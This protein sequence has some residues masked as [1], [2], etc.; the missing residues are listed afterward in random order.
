MI[1]IIFIF[2]LYLCRDKILNLNG[3]KYQRK[4]SFPFH[5]FV[6]HH[7]LS[8]VVSVFFFLNSLL[9]LSKVECFAYS[10]SLNC[11]LELDTFVTFTIHDL[12][13]IMSFMEITF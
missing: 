11:L 12:M 3:G 1:I 8:V 6:L 5:S 7:M 9:L 13:A 2:V 4:Y 10:L